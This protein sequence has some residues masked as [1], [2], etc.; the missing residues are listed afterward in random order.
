VTVQAP[1]T[2][3]VVATDANGCTTSASFQVAQAP[4]ATAAI[5]GG[6]VICDGTSATLTVSGSTG[7]Y[8][9]QDGS[10]GN[11]LT[12]ALTGSY[13]VT[14]TDANGC[15]ASASTILTVAPPISTTVAN[16][17]CRPQEAGTQQFTFSAASGCDSVV[18][19]TTT[20]QP[21][22][23][24]LAL[25][26]TPQ[27]EAEENELITLD[28]TANFPI[29]SVAFETN[30]EL[31]CVDCLD[32]SLTATESGDILVLA[33]NPEGCQATTV[34]QILVNKALNIY[35]PNAFQPGSAENGFF[36]VFSGQNITAVK[37]FNVFDRWGNAL[38]QR[39][40][41]PTNDPSAGWDGTFRG[42]RMQPGVYVYFFEVTLK[43]GSVELFS[44]DVSILE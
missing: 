43:D 38:F 6:G 28:V 21:T 41:M 44:G 14:V 27:I 25:D 5:S 37:N 23:P 16:T 11:S 12:A 42:Q 10:N 33:F 31:S 26:M 8:Q 18:T 29:D 24:G 15:E 39:K 40:D 17:S 2:Y 34:V 9:W 13:S 20:Y 4:P 30:F 3:A 1:G 7:Q 19:V 36:S 22:V 32:P 35:V